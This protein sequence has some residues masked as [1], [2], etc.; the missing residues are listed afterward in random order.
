[1]FIVETGEGLTDANSYVATAWADS[2]FADRGNSSWSAALDAAKQVALV[3]AADYVDASYYFPGERL[4]NTQSLKWP[5]EYA[6]DKYGETLEGVPVIL[7][8]A[9]AELAVRALSEELLQDIAKQGYIKR[10]RVEGAVEIEYGGDGVYPTKSFTYIDRLL[11]SNGVALS[12]T[13]S[14]SNR[15]IMRV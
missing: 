6:V 15:K 11:I 8:K 4:T 13:G 1:M 10:E 14:I 12:K 3:K 9:V 7:M 5:R 2:Y